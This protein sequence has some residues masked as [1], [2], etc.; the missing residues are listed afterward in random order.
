[1]ARFD[2]AI[3]PG[4]EGEITLKLKTKGYQGTVRKSAV[5]YSNDPKRP[6][7][8]LA[9]KAR[10]KVP[11]SFEPRGVM[12]AGFVGDE[13][14]QVVTIRSH[15]EQPLT[16]ELAQ[17]SLPK[18]VAYE[19]KSVEEGKLYQLILRNISKKQDKYSGFITLKTNY[20][21]K[22]EI[23][24]MFLGHIKGNLGFRPETINFGRIDTARLKKLKNR[25]QSPYQRSVMV[26]LNQGDNLKI[27]KIEINRELFETHV[28]EI[29]AGK[30][31][32][33]DVRLH[34]EKLP[35]GIVN[36][37]MRVYTNLKDDPIK[38]IPIQVQKM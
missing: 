8:K 7:I 11:I 31:Y 4:G 17:L 19:L 14:K 22:P 18:K 6:Q 27:G 9:V 12:L 23:T 2:R 20:P 5:V 38:V 10:V 36:E 29:L 37:K 24:V 32:R 26:S 15:K 25:G 16:L 3:P 21:Q 30:S 33:I 35:K 1:V 13:I 34:P 28:K